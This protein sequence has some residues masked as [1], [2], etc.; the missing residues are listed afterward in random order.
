FYG[1]KGT[2]QVGSSGDR[3]QVFPEEAFA[4][5]ISAE[6]VEGLR[7]EDT[8]AHLKNWFECIRSGATPNGS[9]DLALRVQT[10]I[11]LAEMS[12]RLKTTCLFDAGARRIIDGS[13]SEIAPLTHGS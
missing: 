4:S 3:V 13:G 5:E 10:I 1:H 12:D 6:T 8:Q 11:S 7:A 2:I 9:I